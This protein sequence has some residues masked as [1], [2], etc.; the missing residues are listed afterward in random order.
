MIYRALARSLCASLLAAGIAVA[1]S[2]T[3]TQAVSV[4]L[5]SAGKVSVASGVVVSNS[6]NIFN[7][8]VGSLT[9]NYRFRTTPA[10]SGSITLRAGADFTPAGGPSV[11][12]GVL[13]YTCGGAGLGTP[14][15][16]SQTVATGAERPVVQIPVSACTGGGG[17]CSGADP[18]SVPLQFTLD[19]SPQYRTG[20]YSIQLIL[21]VS[22]L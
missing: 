7:N 6:G 22:T 4:E 11:G 2:G 14:C 5:D 8:Y 20:S 3:V 9:V 13:A 17:A 1:G 10:G 12:A 18:A 15:S 19:N 16:G 21:T